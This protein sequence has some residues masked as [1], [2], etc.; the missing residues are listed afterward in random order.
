MISYKGFTDILELEDLNLRSSLSSL[1]LQEIKAIELVNL[2]QVKEKAYFQRDMVTLL[3]NFMVFCLK[4]HNAYWVLIEHY[5]Q[6][7]NKI[8]SKKGLFLQHKKHLSKQ[9]IL[10]T[11]I[12]TSP[13]MTLFAG[14][15]RLTEKNIDYLI[16]CFDD[17]PF[18]FGLIAPQGARPFKASR[19]KFLE[20]IVYNGLTPGK[21]YWKNWLKIAAL[22]IKP[23]RKLFTLQDLHDT[24]HFRVFYHKADEEWGLNLERFMS[25][26]LRTD[27]ILQ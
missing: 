18:A 27:P 6:P 20:T 22:L 23:G 11:E 12:E 24:E 3:K 5:P 21:I 19:K 10:E 7:K 25:Q 16:H 9:T 26:E 8:R 13:G 17:L 14:I 1:T 4:E 2:V 15:I